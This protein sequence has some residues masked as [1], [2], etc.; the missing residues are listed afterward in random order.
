M[1]QSLEHAHCPLDVLHEAQRILRTGG[2]L[3][4]TVPNFDSCAARWFGPSWFG[5]DVPRHL[6]HFTPRTLESM[7]YRAG[8]ENVQVR[9]QQRP[10][11]I[12]HS[13]ELAEARGDARKAVRVLQSRWASGLCGWWGRL[14]GRAD[15][16]LAVAVKS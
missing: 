3:L 1:R 6:T 16:I 2:R 13:A 12:R 14:M 7:L 11:W 15:C 8:F 5:L 9:Q 10:G 4:I